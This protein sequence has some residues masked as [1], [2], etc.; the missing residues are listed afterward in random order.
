MI[1]KVYISALATY[2]IEKKTYI[3]D[4]KKILRKRMELSQWYI[5]HLVFIYVD[6]CTD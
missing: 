2:I 5:Y 4:I 6:I 1:T 3:I